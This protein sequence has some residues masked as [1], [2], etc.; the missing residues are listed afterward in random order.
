MSA[1]AVLRD[2]QHTNR[3]DCIDGAWDDLDTIERPLLVSLLGRSTS[4]LFQIRHRH[5]HRHHRQLKI[6]SALA[7]LCGLGA[8]DEVQR[9]YRACRAHPRR[10]WSQAPASCLGL[11]LALMQLARSQS[12]QEGRCLALTWRLRF[13]TTMMRFFNFLARKRGLSSQHSLFEENC[14]FLPSF[15]QNVQPDLFPLFQNRKK[16][17]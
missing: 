12:R 3:S 10:C 6:R 9:Q 8:H 4:C 1:A 17:S 2:V 7:P 13:F 5:H 15:A 11:D 16:K 14:P